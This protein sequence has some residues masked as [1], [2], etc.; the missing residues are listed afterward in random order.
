MSVLEQINEIIRRDI[1]NENG[2][3][4][5]RFAINDGYAFGYA[6]LS[7]ALK[8]LNR[9]TNRVISAEFITMEGMVEWLNKNGWKINTI[10]KS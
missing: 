3:E 1:T 10:S 7:Y 8:L 4:I 6:S 2:Y 5:V 9:K